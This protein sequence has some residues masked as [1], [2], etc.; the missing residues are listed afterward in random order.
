MHPTTTKYYK[1]TQT[2]R[3]TRENKRGFTQR[4]RQLTTQSDDGSSVDS[5]NDDNKEPTPSIDGT[6]SDESDGNASNS[7]SDDETLDVSA[8]GERRR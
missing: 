3:N 4:V 7:D 1:A 5:A 8:V 2:S 6:T